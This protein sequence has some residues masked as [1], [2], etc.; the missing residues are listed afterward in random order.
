MA[1]VGCLTSLRGSE[2][3][4]R[5]SCAT[6]RGSLGRQAVTDFAAAVLVSGWGRTV[7]HLGGASEFGEGTESDIQLSKVG[8]STER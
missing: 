2:P 7:S 6:A 1:T 4:E 3:H 5:A 8:E